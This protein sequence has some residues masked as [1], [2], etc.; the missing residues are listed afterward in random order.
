MLQLSGRASFKGALADCDENLANGKGLAT[1]EKL[2]GLL[3]PM[4][5]GIPVSLVLWCH[6]HEGDVLAFRS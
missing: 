6:E 1:L 2:V 4:H 3:A 5:H